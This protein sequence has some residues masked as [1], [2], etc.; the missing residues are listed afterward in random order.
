ME[1]LQFVR[2]RECARPPVKGSEF[3]A[4]FD[5]HAADGVLLP[6]GGRACIGTGLQLGIPSGCYGRIAPR[7]GLAAKHGI[8]V[9]A[10]VVDRDFRGEI[11]VLLFNFGDTAIRIEVGDR[12]A[13][14]VLERICEANA[15]EVAQLDDTIRGDGGFGSTGC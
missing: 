8:D 15:V 1:S 9:G 4:G 7:S 12:I 14:V 11:K 10:G 5:L 6:P 2:L 13:Q 3:S